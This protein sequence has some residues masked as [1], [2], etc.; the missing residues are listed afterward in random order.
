MTE[1]KESGLTKN[2][3]ELRNILNKTNCNLTD[4]MRIY[5]YTPV[6]DYIKHD[7]ALGG[8]IPH[9]KRLRKKNF[10]V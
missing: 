4:I 6:S 2:A 3:V 1:K 7:A 9:K 5:I 8:Y 10:F